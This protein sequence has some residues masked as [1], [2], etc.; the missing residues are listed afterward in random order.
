LLLEL[1]DGRIPPFAVNAIRHLRRLGIAPIIA[2]PERNKAVMA[3]PDCLEQFIGEGCLLQLTAASLVGRFGP[4]AER[5]AFEL[6]ARE[7]VQFVASD[8]HNRLHRPPMMRPA[9]KLLAQRFGSARADA[10]TQ[11]GPAAL[12]AGRR[13][14]GMDEA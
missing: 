11:T 14:L 10:L 13:A 7:W 8:A 6:L 12:I 9:R 1:H 3:N 4:Q 2:H 5:T